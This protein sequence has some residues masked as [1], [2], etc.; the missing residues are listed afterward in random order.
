M[1]P[2][3]W[4]RYRRHSMNPVKLP[5]QQGCVSTGTSTSPYN[6]DQNKS[7]NTNRI[8]SKPKSFAQPIQSKTSEKHYQQRIIS[9]KRNIKH[10][11][12]IT[13]ELNRRSRSTRS[14]PQSKQ[15]KNKQN[16]YY[17][18]NWIDS[19]LKSFAQPIRSSTTAR[20]EDPRQAN[21]I[22]TVQQETTD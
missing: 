12:I 1:E 3:K 8:N 13:S 15:F 6:T 18:T 21:W 7:Y 9:N 5:G 20:Y 10:K 16:T 2:K 17:I 11:Q 19:K 14:A 4:R 22:D